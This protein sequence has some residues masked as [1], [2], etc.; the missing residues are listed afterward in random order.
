MSHG[1]A[2]SSQQRLSW[3]LHGGRAAEVG[4]GARKENGHGSSGARLSPHLM[5]GSASSPLSGLNTCTS[6]KRKWLLLSSTPGGA[7]WPD[8]AAAPHHPL[9]GGQQAVAVHR[10]Q[11]SSTTPPL[12]LLVSLRSNRK[13]PNDC[14]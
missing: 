13:D 1:M 7:P 9:L 6:R 12:S 8:E 4:G 2:E 5:P 10:D 11:V 14:Y 3:L